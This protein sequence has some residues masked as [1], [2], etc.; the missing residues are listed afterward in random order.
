MSTTRKFILVLSALSLLGGCAVN[1]S[2]TLARKPM[3][4]LEQ[5][6]QLV[7]MGILPPSVLEIDAELEKVPPNSPR[8]LQLLKQKLA[9]TQ[10]QQNRLQAE[11]AQRPPVS[12][13]SQPQEQEQRM[14]SV[15]NG[16]AIY[17][18]PC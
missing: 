9:V 14:C 12:V 13:P 8:A 15:N 11:D 1:H 2:D 5:D 16:S 10:Q 18:V 17:L 3:S 6:Q 7:A 4:T